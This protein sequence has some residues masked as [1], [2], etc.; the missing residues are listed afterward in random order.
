MFSN[1]AP[2]VDALLAGGCG[3]ASV[4]DF[5]V[6]NEEYSKFGYYEIK[7]GFL[8]AM[9]SFFVIRRIGEGL[10]KQLL[11]SAEIINGKKAYEIGFVNYLY[12]LH[13]ACQFLQ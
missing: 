7:I 8:P 1:W 9:V 10:A 5:I 11:M 4:C 13:I 6:A 3:L 2:V 12:E